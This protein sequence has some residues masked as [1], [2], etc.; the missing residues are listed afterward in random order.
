ML[1]KRKDKIDKNRIRKQPDRSW[2][3]RSVIRLDAD[4]W[5]ISGRADR[6]YKINH[7][8]ANKPHIFNYLQRAEPR[9]VVLHLSTLILTCISFLLNCY[10][11]KQE[12]ANVSIWG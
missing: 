7:I 3:A 5:S 6:L 11:T 2:G 4:Q 12:A 9:A 1:N 8:K 10:K